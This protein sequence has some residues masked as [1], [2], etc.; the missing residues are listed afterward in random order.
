MHPVIAALT[1][2]CQAVTIHLLNLLNTFGVQIDVRALGSECMMVGAAVVVTYPLLFLAMNLDL[3]YRPITF[4]KSV[5]RWV[6]ISAYTSMGAIFIPGMVLM[7]LG[8][9]V[10][11]ALLPTLII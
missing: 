9:I 5:N 2:W 6:N 3:I 8:V 10:Q 11:V 4:T 7:F 1:A